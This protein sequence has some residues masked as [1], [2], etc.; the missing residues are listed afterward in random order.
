MNT[1]IK[2]VI[3]FLFIVAVFFFFMI[4]PFGENQK[5]EI[6]GKDNKI[7]ENNQENI[8]SLAEKRKEEINKKYDK[9][10]LEKGKEAM[11]WGT[12]FKIGET[13]HYYELTLLSEGLCYLYIEDGYSEPMPAQEGR[14]RIDA[15]TGKN[16][17]IVFANDKRMYGEFIDDYLL[18]DGNKYKKIEV[19]LRSD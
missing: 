5:N 15:E 19:P 11:R 3:I 14:W 18:L 9:E 1:K 10:S 7:I 8:K 2:Y 4:L 6:P 13:D 12:H 16:H 17:I